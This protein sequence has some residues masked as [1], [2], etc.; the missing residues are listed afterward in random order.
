MISKEYEF[1]FCFYEFS[2]WILELFRQYGIL[3]VFHLILTRLEIELKLSLVLLL[4]ICVAKFHFSYC[5]PLLLYM[6]F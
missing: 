3:F 2:I 1:R 6:K 4:I 5:Q